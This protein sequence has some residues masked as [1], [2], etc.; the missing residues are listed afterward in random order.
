MEKVSS[1]VV[2]FIVLA[3]SITGTESKEQVGSNQFV[4]FGRTGLFEEYNTPKVWPSFTESQSSNQP[5][6][7]LVSESD[8]DQATGGKDQGPW[9]PDQVDGNKISLNSRSS[10]DLRNRKLFYFL[11]SLFPSNQGNKR[12]IYKPAIG[13]LVG[14]QSNGG[15]PAGIQ[16][17][18][19]GE[20]PNVQSFIRFG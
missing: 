14:G 13:S 18:N 7:S 19:N 6:N 8:L 3:L 9:Q 2:V 11:R 16:L 10:S 12:H 5:T 1:I 20:L 15:G 4:R 17:D